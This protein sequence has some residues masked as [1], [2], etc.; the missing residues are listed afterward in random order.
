M[1]NTA[2]ALGR[3]E[4][5]GTD[6]E[7]MTWK[8]AQRAA[9]GDRE[10]QEFNM[11]AQTREDVERFARAFRLDL[12]Q[13]DPERLARMLWVACPSA[14]TA[15]LRTEAGDMILSAAQEAARRDGR[16]AAEV[17]RFLIHEDLS[18]DY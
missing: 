13:R 1:R 3:T 18:D 6:P 17:A 16:T 8:E 7:D 11:D 12:F 9:K 14:A 10:P 15:M 4:Q 2:K 5:G